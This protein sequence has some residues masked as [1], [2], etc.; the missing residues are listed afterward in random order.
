MKLKK[1]N[2]YIIAGIAIV[3]VI[4]IAGYLYI[5]PDVV[6]ADGTWTTD[7]LPQSTADGINGEWEVDT[8]LTLKDGTRKALSEYMTEGLW[9]TDP[10]GEEVVT[11]S[12]RLR[13][14]AT[15]DN[16]AGAYT[17]VEIDCNELILQTRFH[18][19]LYPVQWIDVWET[20]DGIHTIT[21][22][23]G[24]TTTSYETIATFNIPVDIDGSLMY[25]GGSMPGLPCSTISEMTASWTLGTWSAEY[26]YEG[27]ARFRGMNSAAGN[28]DWQSA[29][30]PGTLTHTVTIGSDVVT[31]DWSHS[32]TY[33]D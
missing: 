17:S 1:Q 11:I 25:S 13:A 30:L 33:S 4:A 31:T 6:S 3:A 24:E 12:H 9:M 14:R 20:Q 28:G 23:A 22:D 2:K 15:R 32:V 5:N 19:T 7:W 21:F 8:I 10:E 16:F 18:P 27:Y 29:S 26:G